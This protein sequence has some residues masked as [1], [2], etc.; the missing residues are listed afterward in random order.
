M[1]F[2]VVFFLPDWICGSPSVGNKRAFLFPLKSADNSVANVLVSL[3]LR[4]RVCVID[5]V[6][7]GI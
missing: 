2:G 6:L 7:E 5:P 3:C 1:F 4:V